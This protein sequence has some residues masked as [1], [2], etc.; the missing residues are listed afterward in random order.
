ML[1]KTNNDVETQVKENNKLTNEYNKEFDTNKKLND[2]CDGIM[3]TLANLRERIE[4]VRAVENRTI[5]TMR[6]DENE[7]REDLTFSQNQF[8]LQKNL[9]QDELKN[10]RDHMND[11]VEQSRFAQMWLKD[12]YA[13]VKYCKKLEQEKAKIFK[14]KNN[15]LNQLIQDEKPRLKANTNKRVFN[16]TKDFCKKLDQRK[17]SQAIDLKRGIIDLSTTKLYNTT[18]NTIKLGSVE[19]TFDSKNGERMY[20][21]RKSMTSPQ[22]YA[23]VSH[24]TSDIY[25]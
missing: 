14:E 19:H 18:Y 6:D 7:L 16:L 17:I 9:W 1:C 8:N 25:T 11:L 23:S 3:E 10:Q 2:E 12:Y 4:N 13:K 22:R 15:I 5:N 24:D 21:S 20:K